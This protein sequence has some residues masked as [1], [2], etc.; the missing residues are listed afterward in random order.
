M[1]ATFMDRVDMH[2]KFITK[3]FPQSMKYVTVSQNS[4]VTINGKDITCNSF[5]TEKTQ[6]VDGHSTTFYVENLPKSSG[7]STSFKSFIPILVNGKEKKVFIYVKVITGTYE[8]IRILDIIKNEILLNHLNPHLPFML[9][10]MQLTNPY[11]MFGKIADE[12]EEY[13]KAL[14]NMVENLIKITNIAKNN[15]KFTRLMKYT[16]STFMNLENMMLNTYDKGTRMDILLFKLF[17]RNITVKELSDDK[18]LFRIMHALRACH[19]VGVVH[20]DLA[21]KN[22]M[23]TKR[24]ITKKNKSKKYI[25]YSI[26]KDIYYL[27][28]V[29]YEPVIIDFGIGDVIDT[30][31]ENVRTSYIMFS[32]QNTGDITWG[33]VNT[34]S[35]V[36]ISDYLILFKEL[37]SDS[38]PKLT[39]IINDMNDC[40]N[41]NN[42]S[43]R[44][45]DFNKMFRIMFKKFMTKHP[46]K[47]VENERSYHIDTSE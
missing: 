27:P 30:M 32:R 28:I 8:E 13:N 31:D 33:N 14:L 2:K 36:M 20:G 39:I 29:K 16:V 47:D 18:Y 5:T 15:L 34:A 19:N 26:D 37:I 4:T 45:F 22:I 23:M 44:I 17:D 35:L 7:F 38:N 11:N 9:S 46:A 21:P 3:F 41:N 12:A 42:I 25:K 6:G 43:P 1:T 40:I 10:H 24:I